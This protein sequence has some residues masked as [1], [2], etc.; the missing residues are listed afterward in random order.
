LAMPAQ[1][2]RILIKTCKTFTLISLKNIFGK[3]A[4]KKTFNIPQGML[5]TGTVY[6]AVSGEV[7]G[8][9]N[10]D[11]S[12][13]AHFTILKSGV[14][15]GNV[16]AENMDLYGTVN[17]NILCSKML[18][19]Q[20]DCVVTGN[21][22]AFEITGAENIEMS[23][24]ISNAG[25]WDWQ[26]ENAGAVYPAGQTALIKNEPIPATAKLAAPIQEEEKNES[27]F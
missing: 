22:D 6:T 21:V 5:V 1:V 18:V 3:A 12:A 15:N 23:G 8:I 4:S 9:V 27:W 16:K 10:G 20:P 11:F 26:A 13:T 14:I 19:L 2:F 25:D 17:G 24:T 7:A